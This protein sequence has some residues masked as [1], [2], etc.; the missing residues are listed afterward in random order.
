[1]AIYGSTS[2]PFPPPDPQHVMHFSPCVARFVQARR[3]AKDDPDGMASMCQSLLANDELETAMRAGDVF[4]AL[5]DSFFER[6]DFQQ[7]YSLIARYNKAQ[8]HKSIS[9]SACN[10]RYSVICSMP[11]YTSKSIQNWQK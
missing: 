8:L 2:F 5:V 11:M 3:I 9:R 1:M 7:C 6:G 10:D 4:A